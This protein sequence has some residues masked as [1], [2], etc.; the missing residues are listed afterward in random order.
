MRTH[1]QGPGSLPTMQKMQMLSPYT[2]F[3][4]RYRALTTICE[5]EDITIIA[6]F[7]GIDYL[8]SHKWFNILHIMFI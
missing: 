5:H 3:C 2:T 4:G 6:M 8:W 7:E 1:N